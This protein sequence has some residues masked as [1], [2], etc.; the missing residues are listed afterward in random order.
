[1]RQNWRRGLYAITDP[2]LVPDARLP[3][4]VE[5]AI[6]GG[7]RLVQFRDKRGASAERTAL[8]AHVLQVCR[9]AGVPLIVNDDLDLAA[10][11]EADGIHLGRGDVL[12]AEARARL[13]PQAV[14]GVSCYDRFANAEQA[15]QAGADYV[16]FGR[17][18]PSRTKPEAV[19]AAPNLLREAAGLGVPVVAIGGITPENGRALVDAGADLLAVVHGVFGQTDVRSA[20]A[21]YARLF[22]RQ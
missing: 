21:A 7:A 17:F 2:G 11:I 6:D 12:P 20:A 19:A 13:G 16:A 3:A 8:A 15:L 22:E 10:E 1:M 5:A 14:L 4:A 18:F 9:T